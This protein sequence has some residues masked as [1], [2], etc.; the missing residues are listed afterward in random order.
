MKFGG[1]SST[2]VPAPTAVYFLAEA[3]LPMSSLLGDE[4]RQPIFVMYL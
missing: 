3:I 4:Q 1:V 2:G